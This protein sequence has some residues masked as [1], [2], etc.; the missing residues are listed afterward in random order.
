MSVSKRSEPL[1]VAPAAVYVI[2][3]DQIRRSGAATL[4]EA[5]RLAPNLEVARVNSQVYAISSRGLN[6]VN[7]SNKLLVL[8]DGRS[9][10]TPFFSSVFWDEQDMMIADIER[11]EVISGPGGA[12]WGANAMNGVVNVVTRSAADTQG[13]LVDAKAGNFLQRAVARWG[14]SIEGGGSFRFYALGSWQGDTTIAATGAN[15]MDSWHGTQAGLRADAPLFVGSLTLLGDAYENII[16]AP[17]G[18]RNGG[19]LLARWV[20]Q[21][22]DGSNLQVQ[23]YYDQ[24]ARSGVAATGGGSSDRVRTFDFQAQHSFVIGAAQQIVWGAGYR[25]WRDKFV[26]TANPFVLVPESETLSITNF[27]A[28]DTIAI[29]DS[30]KLTAGVKFEY[31]TFTGWATMPSVR[32]GW[33]TD[34]RNFLWAAVSRAVRP[35][36]RLERDLTAPGIVERSPDFQ[37]EKLIAYEAGWRAQLLPEATLSVSVFYN[38]Y[39]DL[40]TTSPN[41][42]TVLPITFGNGLAGHTYGLDAWGTY[43]TA[44]WWRISPGVELLRKRFHLEP[45]QSDIAGIQTVLGHDPA[46]QLFLRSY[47][48]LPN[49]CEL[50]VGLRQIGKLPSVDVPAYFEADARL[51][52]RPLP[53]VELALVGQNLIHAR[54]AEATQP[55]VHEIPRSFY[56]GV[57]W[58]F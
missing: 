3:A 32:A 41:P 8:I 55:P 19:D 29:T 1:S 6:S 23:A 26:N 56:F 39:T 11:I 22:A 52:Y 50:Y 20:R 37:S 58:S 47:M 42:V 36:S 35:P 2:T 9:V 4:A 54:H 53:N 38:D 15:A 34:A 45:G 5:L 49:N 27:F 10:Y 28:Q 16:D 31:S 25:S 57:R 18:R 24:Q 33:Q 17:G 48:D 13:G 43:N 44:S 14:G 40:R 7:A 21:L 46:H 51:A 30:V 12:L